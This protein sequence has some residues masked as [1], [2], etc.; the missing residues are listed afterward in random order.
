MVSSKYYNNKITKGA[1]NGSITDDS[2]SE[3][4]DTLS[5][6]DLAGG[7]SAIHSST[8]DELDNLLAKVIIGNTG[9]DRSVADFM[10]FMP[11]GQLS[12][13]KTGGGTGFVALTTPTAA[14][15]LND[16]VTVNN[17]WDAGETITI[18]S[19]TDIT[20]NANGTI[21][22]A[23]DTDISGYKGVDGVFYIDV[24]GDG[25]IDKAFSMATA[26]TTVNL[27]KQLGDIDYMNYKAMRYAAGFDN[28][29]L[30][31]VIAN[32]AGNS[33]L[34]DPN[35]QT[36][37]DILSYSSSSRKAAFAGLVN[38]YYDQ[39][40]DSYSVGTDA[41]AFFNGLGS[42]YS[43]ITIFSTGA[44]ET[45]SS[46]SGA[47][48]EAS[49]ENSAPLVFDNLEHLFMS[50]V[51]VS[52]SG[53]GTS[54]ATSVTGYAPTGKVV[55]SQW[56]VDTNGDSTVDTYYKSRICGIGGTGTST[57]DPWCFSAAGVTNELAVASMAGA[58]G[59]L[60]SAF[61]YMDNKQIFLLMALTSD[62][63]ALTD[64][65]LQNIYTLPAYYQSLVDS[66]ISTYANAFMQVFGYG[67]PNLE[68][69]TLPSSKIYYYSTNKVMPSDGKGGYWVTRSASVSQLSL[70]KFATSGAFG[71]RSATISAPVFDIVESADGNVSIPRV[72]DNTFTLGADSARGLYMGDLL[73]EFKTGNF[74]AVPEQ[75]IG[76]MFSRISFSES[77]KD[78]DNLSGLDIMQLG[79]NSD[80]ITLT[81]EFSR[82]FH[83]S[84][85]VVA[86]G[87]TS[88]PI[89]SLASNATKTSFAWK[90]GNWTFGA[91]SLNGEITDD[92]LMENDPA[93]S[94][95]YLPA[96]IGTVN[97]AESSVAYNA[98]IFKFASS[99]GTMNESDTILGAYTDGLLGL[100]GGTTTYFDTKVETNIKDY[101][102]HFWGRATFAQTASHPTG[103]LVSNISN[104]ESDAFSA[105]VDWKGFS[106][107]VSQP[108]AITNG[109][110][111]YATMNYDVVENS[112]G[113]YDLDATPYIGNLNLAPNVRETRLSGAY[114]AKLGAFTD[115]AI[116]FI[117]RINP[118]HTSEFGNESVMMFKV[119]HR[120]GI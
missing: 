83:D 39:V 19:V 1:D 112:S 86:R 100:G 30:T 4:S 104:I 88:N 3:N 117:Y 2:A 85:N 79:Y 7:G 52:V 45:D 72:W 68:R 105:G 9:G 20:L 114:R 16:S 40:S 107:A 77:V 66:G 82:H 53:T 113:G 54:G 63:Q 48:K 87:D 119:V 90:V 17:A 13:F 69:A 76:N 81:G 102:L 32:S 44:S 49:F 93:I 97:A 59:S 71:S 21:T 94:G 75:R 80:D 61:D 22:S 116:G 24:D 35:S 42:T 106:F 36:I 70:T 55:L 115:G 50:V 95:Q 109:N 33:E 108:L 101:G 62:G 60:Q 26:S 38:Q 11:N 37:S 8:A 34:Y 98:G 96:S 25:V 73:G 43:P 118:N 84:E 65:E 120:L 12:V 29:T 51:A 67:L 89:L 47:P 23:S 41:T 56:G 27:V 64:A 18:G 31:K 74:N 91:L 111:E 14:G 99:V 46:F 28:G 103:D 78:G 15:T 92:G 58:V 110:M 6:F 10:G 5:V 57:I